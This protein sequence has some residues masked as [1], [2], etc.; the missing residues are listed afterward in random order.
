MFLIHFNLLANC[1]LLEWHFYINIFEWYLI[2]LEGFISKLNF[3]DEI[4]VHVYFVLKY[5]VGISALS[6]VK[7]YNIIFFFFSCVHVMLN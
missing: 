6:Q 3:F 4:G 7:C 1:V 2:L 5:F